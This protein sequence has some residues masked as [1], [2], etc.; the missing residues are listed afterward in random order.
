MSS[1]NGSKSGVSTPSTQQ[2][3]R[4]S[5]SKKSLD[6]AGTGNLI[7]QTIAHLEKNKAGNR[8]QEQEIGGFDL[9][10]SWAHA[11]PLLGF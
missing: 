6:A 5:K 11:M 4:K 10:I 2:G 1:A 8:E 3:T 7:N 9:R